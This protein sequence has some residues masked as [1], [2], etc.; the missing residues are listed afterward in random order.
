MTSTHLTNII[1]NSE[2]LKPFL[3]RSRKRQRCPLLSLLFNTVL[4]VLTT[5]IR[6]EKEIKRIQIGKKEL[7]LPLFAD[8]MLLYIENPKDDTR[9]RLE[10]TN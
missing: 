8:G 10:L 5:A 7:K 6:Q 2:K 3:L 9:K 1:L 4:E